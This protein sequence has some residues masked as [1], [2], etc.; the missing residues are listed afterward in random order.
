MTKEHLRDAP[1]QATSKHPL[2]LTTS[3]TFLSI[4]PKARSTYNLGGIVYYIKHMCKKSAL[5]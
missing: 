4:L 2:N 1:L 5:E 3:K